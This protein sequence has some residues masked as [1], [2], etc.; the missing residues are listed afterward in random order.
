M[1]CR[2]VIEQKLPPTSETLANVKFMADEALNSE[3]HKIH[4]NQRAAALEDATDVSTIIS[5][6]HS[7]FLQTQLL[8][9]VPRVTIAAISMAK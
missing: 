3:P 5:V 6:T 1:A 7:T 2:E 8:I 4:F 9:Q